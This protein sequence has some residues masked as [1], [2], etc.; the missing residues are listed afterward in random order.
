MRN[1][2]EATIRNLKKMLEIKN[3]SLVGTTT[4]NRVCLKF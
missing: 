4:L 3:K 1:A 2:K